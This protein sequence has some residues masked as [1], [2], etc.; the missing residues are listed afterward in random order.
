MVDWLDLLKTEVAKSNI[1]QVANQIGYARTSV[2]LALSGKYVGSTDKLAA[3]VLKAYSDRFQCPHLS[4]AITKDE[5]A[6]FS[7]RSIPQSNASA[8]RHWRACQSCPH[9]RV[10]E[11]EAWSEATGNQKRCVHA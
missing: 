9:N 11:Q 3:A 2:S 8:L 1:T 7:S 4:Q 5:C 6:G 10:S